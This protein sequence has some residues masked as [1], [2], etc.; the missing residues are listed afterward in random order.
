MSSHSTQNKSRI[1]SKVLSITK[2]NNIGTLMNNINDKDP[3]QLLQ[4]ALQYSLIFPDVEHPYGKS[5]SH[6]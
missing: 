2:Y 5:L 4:D 6:P 1:C 3:P